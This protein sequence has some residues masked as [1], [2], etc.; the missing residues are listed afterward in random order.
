MSSK[1][2]ATTY[3][4]DFT[5]KV[6]AAV[7]EHFAGAHMGGLWGTWRW[8]DLWLGVEIDVQRRPG[9]WLDDQLHALIHLASSDGSS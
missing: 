3:L 9:H 4:D 1:G 5:Q 6:S 7:H 2:L 8:G